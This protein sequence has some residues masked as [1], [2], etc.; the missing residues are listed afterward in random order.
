[1][2]ITKKKLLIITTYAD[3]SLPLFFSENIRNVVHV[4]V[5]LYSNN[6]E[7]FDNFLDVNHYDFIYLRD[8]FNVED[9]NID[10][11]RSNVESVLDRK[12]DASFIDH[13]H[14]FDDI[15]FEDKWTQYE[16]L[17]QYMSETRLADSDIVP[18]GYIAKKRLSQRS[19]GI[20]LS[21]LLPYSPSEYV[22]QKRLNIQKEYRVFSIGKSVVPL[23]S[24]KTSKSATSGVKVSGVEMLPDN[25]I[26]FC[27]DIAQ[28]VNFDFSGLDVAETDEGIFLLEVNR[29]PQ[30]YVY[31]RESKHNIAELL[32]KEVML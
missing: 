9:Y 7:W 21:G 12:C 10:A 28:K 1:M 5:L 23:A 16:K 17:R 32:V 30:F 25:I 18:E 29:S 8:P 2:T 24:V 22:F 15:L 13:I 31:F 3:L 14:S 19:K 27:E 6:K 26:S 4:D 20:V 11:I